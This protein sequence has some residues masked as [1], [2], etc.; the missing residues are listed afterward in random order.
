MSIRFSQMSMSSR[1]V[2]TKPSSCGTGHWRGGPQAGQRRIGILPEG[3]H[4]DVE[5]RRGSHHGILPLLSASGKAPRR[6]AGPGACRADHYSRRANHYPCGQMIIPAGRGA[7]PD[8]WSASRRWQGRP[9][10]S[11]RTEPH[12][13]APEEARTSPA[14]AHSPPSPSQSR[15]GPHQ[16]AALHQ[17][18]ACRQTEAGRIKRPARRVTIRWPMKLATT[19][20]PM[21]KASDGSQ[22][23][24]RSRNPA[25]LDGFSM[26]DRARP[27]PNSAPVSTTE[28]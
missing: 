3:I 16:A 25:T 21:T 28:I 2:M 14:P 8:R 19:P 22:T 11:S 12:R 5:M 26:P 18:P 24:N 4:V 23:P 9:A 13:P 27:A 17:C 6:P 15:T 10:S 7:P 20:P 1:R